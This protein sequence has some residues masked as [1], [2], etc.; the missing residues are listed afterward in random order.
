[1]LEQRVSLFLL[2][3]GV[4]KTDDMVPNARSR[5]WVFLTMGTDCIFSAFDD[6]FA[7]FHFELKIS[8]AIFAL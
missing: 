1:M 8:L 7:G 6:S 3:S 4:A 5:S 2:V